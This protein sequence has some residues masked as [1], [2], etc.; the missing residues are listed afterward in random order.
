[1][2]ELGEFSDSL[3]KVWS[4]ALILQEKKPDTL[5]NTDWDNLKTVFR[6]IRCMASGTSLVGNS[7]VTSPSDTQT[8]LPRLI[9]IIRLIFCTETA[10]SK[11]TL[12]ASGISC[13][14]FFV[15]FFIQ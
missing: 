1:M 15:V 10:K 9:E 5:S 14:K 7:K 6:G 4:A 8:L 3:R 12:M 11:M 13:Q 2:K